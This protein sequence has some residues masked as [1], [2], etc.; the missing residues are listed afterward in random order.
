MENN[1]GAGPH[2]DPQRSQDARGLK[3]SNQLQLPDPQR[4]FFSPMQIVVQ[5]LNHVALHVRDLTASRRFYRDV[6]GLPEIPRPAFDFEGAWFALGNQVL[7][8]IVNE[9][10]QEADR[11]HHHFALR[12]DDPFEVKAWLANRGITD[13]EG[14][15]RRPDGAMQL[16]LRDPDGYRI[17]MFNGP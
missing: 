10:L 15:K 1:D 8:L 5:E 14:P 17:E 12:V 7:H 4:N 9:S 6:L 13:F 11:G 16:F 3:N 2:S